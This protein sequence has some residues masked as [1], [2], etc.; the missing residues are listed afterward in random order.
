MATMKNPYTHQGVGRRKTAV[1]R[2][3]LAPGKGDMEINGRRLEDY[4][5]R[6][7]HRMEINRPFEV[8][9]SMGRFRIHVTVAGGG[10]NGQA[11][12]VRHGIARALQ[13][14]SD[15]HR[16]ALKGAGL[17]TR[18]SRS[19]ERKKYGQSG[20]RRRFQYSKR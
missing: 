4:F 8:T 11:E 17:L 20:A 5:P 19:V 2:V 1:A 16:A 12:A 10:A 13:G 15:E 7:S 18:D 3:Y 14:I 6:V 9:K